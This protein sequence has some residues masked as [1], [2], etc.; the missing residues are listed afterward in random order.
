MT[1]TS[2]KVWNIRDCNFEI[3]SNFEF[4]ALNLPIIY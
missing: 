2:N 4:R 3:A 1:E